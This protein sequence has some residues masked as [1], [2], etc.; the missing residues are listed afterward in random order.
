MGQVV[1]VDQN[2]AVGE[3]PL[4][5]IEDVEAGQFVDEVALTVEER[6]TETLFFGAGEVFQNEE[7][8]TLG[9]PV[10]ASREK[11]QMLKAG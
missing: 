11:M 4:V 6:E 1:R 5:G 8:E 2:E 9:F 7:L 10:P 3:C